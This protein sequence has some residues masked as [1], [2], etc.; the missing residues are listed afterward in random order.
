MPDN[1][2]Y[3]TIRRIEFCI[4]RSVEI[5][6]MCQPRNLEPRIYPPNVD[7]AARQN[8]RNRKGHSQRVD[9]HAK[10]F[11]RRVFRTA[12]GTAV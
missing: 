8:R 6:T 1:F 2:T 12:K 10:Q 11:Y 4:Y 5:R 9:C 3:V 7:Q